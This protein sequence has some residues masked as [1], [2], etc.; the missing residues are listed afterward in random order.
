MHPAGVQSWRSGREESET[1][2]AVR[3]PKAAPAVFDDSG[4][5][6][7]VQNSNQIGADILAEFLCSALR[8]A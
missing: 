4:I 6:W 5:V 1:H 7:N 8:R 2:L 3:A